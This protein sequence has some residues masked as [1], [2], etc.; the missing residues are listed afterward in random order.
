MAGRLVALDKCPGIRPVGTGETWKR[1]AAK[2]VI[3]ISKEEVKDTCGVDQLC[4]GLKA[5]VDGGIHCM[6]QTWKQHQQ[7]EEWG[8]LLIDARNAFNEG[9]RM[10]ML[11]NVR[12]EWPSGARFTFNCH[13]HWST[14]FVRGSDGTATT[15]HSEEGVTQ[16]CPL[17]MFGCGILLLPLIRSL[18]REAKA[19]EQ[20]WH[21]DDSSGAG[22]FKNFV[23]FATS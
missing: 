2:V 13:R 8:F 21:A 4:A 12:H 19:I 9:N 23:L 22:K 10:L 7:K 6:E 11:W 1:L 16:G 15:T 18:K 5:G 3:L 20:M 17:A 14:L